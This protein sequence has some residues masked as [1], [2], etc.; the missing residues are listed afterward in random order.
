MKKAAIALFCVVGLSAC[1]A[2]DEPDAVSGEAVADRLEKAADQSSPAAREV[3]KDAA[4][5]ARKQP[6]LDP[7]DEPGS[8]AQEAME[9]AGNAEA[10]STPS[11][12]G[13]PAGR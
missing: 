4:A 13:A 3:L 6:S 8:F 5:E 10:P 12:S 2:A 7:V 11:N 1:G 9:K